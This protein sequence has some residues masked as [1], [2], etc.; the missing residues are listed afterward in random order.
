MVN[1]QSASEFASHQLNC[2]TFSN[3]A[4]KEM[5]KAN[6]VFLQ[7]YNDG[8]TGK[9]LMSY[10]H[11]EQFPCILIIDPVTG[12]LMNSFYGFVQPDRSLQQSVCTH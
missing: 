1:V 3:E 4:L 7:T 12:G 5:I 6:F 11:L 9:K 8:V 10:Y 2:D